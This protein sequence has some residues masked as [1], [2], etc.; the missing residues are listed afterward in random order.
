MISEISSSR[1]S[2][3]LLAACIRS[4]PLKIFGR[5]GSGRS[6]PLFDS[7]VHGRDVAQPPTSPP[8]PPPPFGPYGPPV[9]Y[10]VPPPQSQDTLV[11]T[12]LVLVIVAVALLAL[13]V[14]A[15]VSLFGTILESPPRPAVA[16]TNVQMTNGN[17]S[18]AVATASERWSRSAYAVNLIVDSTVGTSRP[19]AASGSATAILAHDPERAH[20]PDDELRFHRLSDIRD[21]VRVRASQDADGAIGERDAPLLGHVVVADHIHGG[22]RRDESDLVDLSGSELTVLD[23]HDVLPPHRLARHVHRHGHG[24]RDGIADPEDLQ[25]L[26]GPPRGDVIDHGPI[27]DRGDAELPHSPPPRMRSRR[28][29]RTGTPLKA[30]LKYTACFVRSTS[31]SISVVRG[32]GC[33]MMRSRLASR[34]MPAS[35]RYDPATS[36][37]SCGSGNRS[38][39]IRVTYST[40]TS[41]I[42]SS[43]RCAT[44]NERPSDFMCSRISRG[45]SSVGG[46]TKISCEPSSARA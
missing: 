29:I 26:Q 38:F 23:L 21:A 31:G 5:P 28:A 33:R 11:R 41:R 19:L 20:R 18:F 22:G 34:S 40:S 39:W 4:D 32:S 25:D 15:V 30:C 9:L 43:S 35:M 44:R 16:F 46:L 2:P 13:V 45:I 7:E 6:G 36:S 42:T 37:Y 17:V 27:L 12:I 10:P 8:Y 1:D 3:S 14:F 24:R